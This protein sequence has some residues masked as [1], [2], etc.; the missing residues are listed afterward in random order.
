MVAKVRLARRTV[1][2]TQLRS[3]RIKMGIVFEL[4]LGAA[5]LLCLWLEV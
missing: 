2:R 4:V 3:K 1:I 5:H